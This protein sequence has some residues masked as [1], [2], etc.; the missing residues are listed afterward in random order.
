MVKK[1][2]SYNQPL[3]LLLLLLLFND[4]YYYYY[5]V[6]P[7][8]TK[9]RGG[10]GGEGGRGHIVFGMDPVGVSVSVKLLVCSVT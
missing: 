10:G 9:G 6:P 4:N 3:L 1:L 2:L 8:P 7:P 5:H